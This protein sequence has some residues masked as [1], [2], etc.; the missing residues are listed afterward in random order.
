MSTNTVENN[1]AISA[2]IEIDWSVVEG[3]N[4][5][6]QDV[7][8]RLQWMHGRKAFKQL[9]E[10]NMNYTGGLFLPADQFPNFSADGWMETSFTTSGTN[11]K[12]IKGWYSKRAFLS[13]LRIKRWWDDD[14]SHVH[15]LVNLRGV[16][17]LF[18]VQVGGVS[19]GVGFENAFRAHRQQI[20][21]LANRS[22][23]A[24]RPGLEPFA[25]WFVLAPG[26]HSMQQSAKNGESSEVTLPTLYVPESLDLDYVRRLWVGS[27]LYREFCGL[28][29]ETENW[30]NQIPKN[31]KP[32]AADPSDTDTIDD[33]MLKQLLD[34]CLKKDVPEDNLAL[35]VS[36]NATNK[37][38]ML[39]FAEAREALQILRDA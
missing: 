33:K 1:T 9:G 30:Q 31:K 14:G 2:P 7:Y 11:G 25:L 29:K 36:N 8:P 26:D 19:K 13:T 20:V 34:L 24:G 38:E 35:T 39:N 10:N 32:A 28:Y 17:G 27:E 16:D 5:D 4:Q 3:N 12:E 21:S 18:C 6:F 37:L 15:A 23:P 22:K